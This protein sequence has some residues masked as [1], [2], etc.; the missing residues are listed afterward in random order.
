MKSL[1]KQVFRKAIWPAAYSLGLERLFARR[2]NKQCA[3]LCYHGVAPEVSYPFNGRHIDQRTFERHLI[4]FKQHFQVESLAEV[5]DRH[6]EGRTPD[7]PTVAITFDDGY[8]NNYRYA[9][10]L[11]NQYECPASF[12][13]S[14]IAAEKVG[15]G[16]ILWPDYI[17]LVRDAVGQQGFAYDGYSF[18][19]VGDLGFADPARSMDGYTY[20]KHLG[21]KERE[22]MFAQIEQQLPEVQLRQQAASVYQQIMT[23]EQIHEAAQSPFIEIGGHG[24]RHYNLAFI[25]RAEAR[26]ELLLSK[27][28]LEAVTGKPVRSIAFPDGNYDAAVKDIA[29][30]LGYEHMLAE[31]YLFPEDEADPRILPRISISGTTNFYSHVVYINQQFRKVGF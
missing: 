16:S 22:N 4:Y 11:L 9:L 15:E 20:I 27:Q 30:E 14:G 10:P 6:R 12:F 25:P 24:H 13:V 7:K 19:K 31:Q 26:T 3:I 21:L 28:A 5:F 17:D 18:Q 29:S 1:V 2:G 23:A 8:W